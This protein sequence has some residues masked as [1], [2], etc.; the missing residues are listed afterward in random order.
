MPEGNV[1]SREQ[2]RRL[3][4][5]LF[6]AVAAPMAIGKLEVSVRPSI[7]IALGLADGA[8]GAALIKHADVALDRA[9][10]QQTGYAFFDERGR[11]WVPGRA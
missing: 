7:G 3:T 9:R 2:L 10:R 1:T 5:K 8:S 6:D 4:C 11:A